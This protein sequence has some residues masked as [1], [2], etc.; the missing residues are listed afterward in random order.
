MFS[1]ERDWGLDDDLRDASSRWARRDEL[2]G[3][4]GEATRDRDAYELMHELQLSGVPAGVVLNGA[5]MLLDPHL[6]ARR[7]YETVAHRPSTGMPPLPYAG[8]PFR[9]SETP[10]SI[11]HPAPLMGQHNRYVLSEVLGRQ[12]VETLEA[13]GVDRQLACGATAPHGHP[14]GGAATSGSHYGLRPA[15]QAARPGGVRGLGLGRRGCQTAMRLT[16]GPGRSCLA[17]MARAII[18]AARRLCRFAMWPTSFQAGRLAPVESVARHA[19]HSDR[20]PSG[21]GKDG[22]RRPGRPAAGLPHSGHRGHVP[23]GDV[24]GVEAGRGPGGPRPSGR[25]GPPAS[26]CGCSPARAATGCSRTGRT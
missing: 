7:F 20:R 2:D 12:D 1:A 15:V 23:G 13:T 10:G 18:R 19:V 4:I 25:A 8:S 24:P 26:I 16:R 11:R 6:K 3:L 14:A 17:G 22:R 9:M 21:L 5:E